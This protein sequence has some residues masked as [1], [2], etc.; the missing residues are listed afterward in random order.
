MLSSSHAKLVGAGEEKQKAKCLR[1][2]R[3]EGDVGFKSECVHTMY[4]YLESS[5]T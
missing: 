2:W 5:I 1:G 4:H 3:K